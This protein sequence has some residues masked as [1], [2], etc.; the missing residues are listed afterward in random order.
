MGYHCTVGILWPNKSRA[1]ST[2]QELEIGP[3]RSLE[4]AQ[5]IL[6]NPGALLKTNFPRGSLILA[7]GPAPDAAAPVARIAEAAVVLGK[8]PRPATRPLA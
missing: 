3:A 7:R 5:V 1:G 2:L 8:G 6:S 4:E